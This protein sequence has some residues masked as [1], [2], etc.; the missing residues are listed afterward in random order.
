MV[1]MNRKL[2]AYHPG[3]LVVEECQPNLIEVFYIPSKE[4]LD[5]PGLDQNMAT[6]CRVK[7]MVINRQDLSLRIFPVSTMGSNDV[8]LKPKHNQVQCITLA[9]GVPVYDGFSGADP[10]TGDNVFE[11]PCFGPTELLTPEQAEVLSEETP[12]PSRQ[13]QIMT[14][15]E[16]L[17]SAF[18]KDYDYGLGLARPYWF[19]VEAVERLSDCT[20]VVISNTRE[21][22]IDHENKIFYISMDDFDTARKTLNRITNLGRK[23]MRSVKD[24]TIFNILADKTGQPK[25]P[26][27]TGRQSTR[28]LLTDAMQNEESLDDDE[29]EVVLRALTGNTRV[30]AQSKPE[31]LAKLQTEIELVTLDL[32]IARYEEMITKNLGEASWQAFFNENPFILNF[33]FGYPVIKVQ[34]Q[35][36][37]GGRKLSGSGEKITDFLV[38]N[39]LT[40]AC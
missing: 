29:Q 12:L 23:A 35:A 10:S 15:L 30:I 31:K 16:S 3:K 25:V 34:D 9:D 17:P 11:F 18:T 14:V 27:K 28:K 26:V 38:K 37:V 19:I 24:A 1:R 40:R 5:Q 39:T 21:T 33:T 2:D 20:E 8:F 7:L 36:S 6:A 4:K 13:E 22:A 32:L